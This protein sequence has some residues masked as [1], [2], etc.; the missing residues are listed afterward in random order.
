[1][2]GAIVDGADGA[3]SAD[4]A[5]YAE[6]PGPEPTVAQPAVEQIKI[7]IGKVLML[8]VSMRFRVY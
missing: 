2:E 6:S 4:D 1:V 3:S 5:G 7:K 8:C